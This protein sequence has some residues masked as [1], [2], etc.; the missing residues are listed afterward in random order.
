MPNRFAEFWDSFTNAPLPLAAYS[1]ASGTFPPPFG[2]GTKATRLR[3]RTWGCRGRLLRR[4][5]RPC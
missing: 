1:A 2:G 3:V 5:P 4:L